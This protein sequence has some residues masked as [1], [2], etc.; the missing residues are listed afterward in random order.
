MRRG[1]IFR[2][3]FSFLL[4]SGMYF[5]GRYFGN[6]N[7]AKVEKEISGDNVGS[8]YTNEQNRKFIE[9]VEAGRYPGDREKN[10]GAIEFAQYNLTSG[11]RA[12]LFDRYV[13]FVV[14]EITD[15]K[16]GRVT[17]SGLPFDHS[18]SCIKSNCS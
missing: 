8:D 6:M 10:V 4:I 1:E 16:S 14:A 17:V 12:K 9:D 5:A 11:A 3:L 13:M 7:T 2:L 15:I 18:Q